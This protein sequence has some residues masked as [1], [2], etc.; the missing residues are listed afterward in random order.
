MNIFVLSKFPDIAARYHCDKHVVKM[1]LES[2]QIIC[3]VLREVYRIDYGYRSTHVNH[4]CTKWAGQRVEHLLWLLDLTKNLCS[5]YNFR[6][7]KIHKCNL[8]FNELSVFLQNQVLPEPL[9]NYTIVTEEYKILVYTHLNFVF[10]GPED[11][12][13]NDIVASYRNY[14]K[15]DKKYFATWKNRNTPEW[16]I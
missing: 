3:T 16:F 11:L 13:T 14:Y 6:Y 5:E 15:R 10:C 1:I 12:R 8:M 9:K 2:M 7:G 4:P